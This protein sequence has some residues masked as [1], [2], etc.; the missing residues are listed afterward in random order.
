MYTRAPGLDN[1]SSLRPLPTV[2]LDDGT[3]AQDYEQM[4]QRWQ[5]HFADIELADILPHDQVAHLIRTARAQPNLLQLPDDLPSLFDTETSCLA[6]RANAAAGPD[7]ITPRLLT[8]FAPQV[9][10]L[11]AP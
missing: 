3:L 11:L 1:K 6:M 5:Q 7:G 2:L 10:R 4:R 9:S 8:L